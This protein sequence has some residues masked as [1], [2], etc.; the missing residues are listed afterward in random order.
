MSADPIY[1]EIRNIR[2]SMEGISKK[3]ETW[4]KLNARLMELKKKVGGQ[5][6]NPRRMQKVFAP[7]GNSKP[8]IK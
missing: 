4:Q 8:L 2:E 5:S 7:V 3:T 6:Y 1:I